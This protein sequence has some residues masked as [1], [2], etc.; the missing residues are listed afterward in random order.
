MV[1]CEATKKTVWLW[2]FL[3]DVEVVPSTSEPIVLH[4]D[5]NGAAASSKILRSSNIG[6]HTNEMY[7]LI[8]EDNTKRIFGQVAS[9]DNLVDSS[10]KGLTIKVRKD[11]IKS[12]GMS[13]LYIY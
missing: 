8:P 11:H 6:I 1:T 13:T 7:N 9:K 5:N 12:K 10:T 4:C 3:I 2:K